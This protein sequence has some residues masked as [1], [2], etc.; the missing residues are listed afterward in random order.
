MS[1]EMRENGTLPFLEPLRIGFG[2]SGGS[3]ILIDAGLESLTGVLSLVFDV[4][5]SEDEELPELEVEVTGL[6]FLGL[7]ERVPLVSE[8]SAGFLTILS[9]T[10]LSES[11]SDD[12]SEEEPDE[13]ELEAGSGIFLAMKWVDESE[14]E[15]E[16]EDESSSELSSALTGSFSFFESPGFGGLVSNFEEELALETLTFFAFGAASLSELESEPELEDSLSDGA[17]RLRLSLLVRGELV[18]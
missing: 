17:F 12:E 4:V 11:E 16:L 5:E 7:L 2:G 14:S 1:A 18:F 8:L 6:S 15:S 13:A 9:L 3:E 10:T